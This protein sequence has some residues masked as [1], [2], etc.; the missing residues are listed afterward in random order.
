MAGWL[1][2]A[3]AVDAAV[4]AA[5]AGSETPALDTAMRRLSGAADNSK[6][7]FATAAVLGDRKSVV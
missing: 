4:Y 6:L 7:W 2:D 3:K 1:S 5:V